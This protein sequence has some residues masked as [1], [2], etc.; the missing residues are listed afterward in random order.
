VRFGNGAITPQLFVY[1]HEA[2]LAPEKQSMLHI[3]NEVF[4]R[5]GIEAEAYQKPLQLRK[6]PLEHPFAHC[7]APDENEELALPDGVDPG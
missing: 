4:W 3:T 1:I 2:R 6:R 5:L 7:D